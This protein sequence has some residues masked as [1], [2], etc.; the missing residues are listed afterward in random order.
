M[1]TYNGE[2]KNTNVHGYEGWLNIKPSTVKAALHQDL[3]YAA[4]EV[5]GAP[6]RSDMSDPSQSDGIGIVDVQITNEG[7]RSSAFAG[8]LVP[9][10]QKYCNFI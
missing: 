8:L 9:Q 10:V 6:I 3:I 4:H 1:E 2:F 5:T 7:M